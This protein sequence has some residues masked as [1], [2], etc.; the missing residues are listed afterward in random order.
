MEPKK[1]EF[2]YL[3]FRMTPENG[4]RSRIE[5]SL[6]KKHCNAV[7]RNFIKRVVRERVRLLKGPFRLRVGTRRPL[8]AGE[9]DKIRGEIG[10]LETQ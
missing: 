9:R 10:K 4:T 8:T 7:M 2:F 1:V 6:R 5:F 3:V